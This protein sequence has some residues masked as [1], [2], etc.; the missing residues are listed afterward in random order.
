MISAAKGHPF[1]RRRSLLFWTVALMASVHF[2][3]TYLREGVLQWPYDYS[4]YA[5]GKVDYP[6]RSRVLMSWVY[7]AGLYLLHSHLPSDTAGPDP[8]F[9]AH[10]GPLY[11]TQ[12]AT[13][14]VALLVATWA[15]RRS[16][17]WFLG[18]NSPFVWLS[19]L[20]FIMVDYNCLLIGDLRV[21]GPYD[22]PSLAF[23]AL[24]LV[25]ILK[26]NRFLYYTAFVVGTF[27][28]ETTLFLPG[29]FLL[30]Q[31]RADLS[32]LPAIRRIRLWAVVEVAAQ[33]AV[34]KATRMFCD[35]LVGKGLLR[36][37]E[38]LPLNLHYLTTPPHY[39]TLLSVFGFLW[40]P[41]WIYYRQIPSIYLRRC[42]LLTIPWMLIM[43]MVGDLLELR[44]HLEWV[45]YFTLCL[46]LILSRYVSFHGTPSPAP[47]AEAASLL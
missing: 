1:S 17:E 46:T 20:L 7:C 26:R 3:F 23:F 45:P 29:F 4:L 12:T 9:F 37:R 24:G 22:V 35:H 47:A 13:M 27:N 19:F 2:T 15:I 33:I 14:V 39:V 10:R 44:I 34:W 6:Y 18:D 30:A 8:Q 42:A 32:L 21:Q 31:L 43:I 36:P 11:Y 40:I 16:I 5:Y 28:R 38:E 41:F 25:A